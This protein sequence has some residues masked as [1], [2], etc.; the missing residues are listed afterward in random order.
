MGEQTAF[1][2]AELEAEPE[3]VAPA[4]VGEAA[5]PAPARPVLGP[6]QRLTRSGLERCLQAF[7]GPGLSLILT[8]NGR[9]MISSRKQGSTLVV[10]VHHMFLDAPGAVLTA[11]G[12]Y[13]SGTNPDAGQLL[14]EYIKSQRGR[15]RPASVRAS[16]LRS[17]GRHHDLQVLF[18][19]LNQRYFDDAVQAR[20]TWAKQTVPR[21][22]MRRSIKLGSYR[23]SESLIRVHPVLDAAWVPEFFVEFIVYH[24]ML[25]QVV[26]PKVQGARREF[27][28]REFRRRERQF[29]EYERSL[30]WEQEHLRRLLR[31]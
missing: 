18:D 1:R 3:C 13:L 31:S 15:I 29:A 28:C 17:A 5:L 9:T 19:R 2:F 8:D 20:I 22:R 26:R 21:G 24:E 6:G 7:C 11:L 23:S 10:R 27:H 30:M 25:H 4:T 12:G 16:Q 14:F